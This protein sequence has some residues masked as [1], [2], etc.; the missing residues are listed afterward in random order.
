MHYIYW[1]LGIV[2]VL[3]LIVGYVVTKSTRIDPQGNNYFT[4]N[5]TTIKDIIFWFPNIIILYFKTR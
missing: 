5:F 2:G 3:Y 1:F 4:W